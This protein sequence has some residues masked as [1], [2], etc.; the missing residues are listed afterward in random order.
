MQKGKWKLACYA[1]EMRLSWLVSPLAIFALSFVIPARGAAYCRTTTEETV[2]SGCPELCQTEGLPLYW[3]KRSLSYVLNER[4]FPHLSD[5]Q[6]RRVL[7]HSFEPWTEAKCAGQPIALTVSQS[8]ETTDLE[9]GP[10]ELEPNENAIAYIA[11]EDW[12]DE[13]R[14]FAITKIWYNARN[15]YILGAD[16]LINGHMDPFGICPEPRGCVDD[17]LTD[18]RNVVTHEAGHFLGLAHSEEEDSTM[19]CDAAPGDID[20]RVL[21]SDDIAGICA[22]YGPGAS[23]GP[24]VPKSQT[25]TGGILCSA[26]PGT[27]GA[28]PWAFG[29]LALAALLAR[30]RQG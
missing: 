11:A 27:R 26:A 3:P 22:I 23:P 12:Q 2:S 14:A 29:L 25:S 4:G 30:R 10:R 24:P 20:K 21:A 19:W 5:K 16:M 6:A 7:Q 1:A 9:A 13:P 18:L 15:G 28:T 8:L 17:S